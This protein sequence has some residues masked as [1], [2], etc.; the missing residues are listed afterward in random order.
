MFRK[1]QKHLQPALMSDIESLPQKHRQRLDCS[2]AGVFYR[3]VFSRLDEG[4]FA[5][6]YADVPSRPNVPVNV[7]VGLETLKA[8][9]GWSDEELYDAFA[10]DLQVRYALGYRNLGEGDFDL[11]TLYY[12]RARLSRYNQEHQVNLIQQAFAQITDQQLTAFKVRTGKQRMDSTQIASNIMDLSRL[13]LAVEGVHRLV[14]LLSESE[15]ERYAELLAP[16]VSGSA[17]H[18][19]YRVKGQEQTRR[20]L[21]EVGEVLHTLLGH[22]RQRCHA[23]AAYQAVARL[24]DENFVVAEEATQVRPN[25]ELHSGCLQ[26]LDDLEAS[27]RYKANREYKGYVANV[28]ETCD[29]DNPVQLITSVQV[30][31]NNTADAELLVEALPQLKARTDVETLITD[32]AYGSPAGDR[33]LQ[34]LQVEQ[35][36]TGFTGRAPDP[37]RLHLSDWDVIQDDQGVPSS[38]TCPGGQ[39]VCLTRT[40]R[41]SFSGRA[42]PERCAVC[43]FYTSGRCQARLGSRDAP[44][45]IRFSLEEFYLAGRRRA[46]ATHQ[47]DRKLRPAVEATMRS[48]KHP[49][50]AGQLPVRGRFRVT[51]MMVC[52]AL[53]VNAR[54]LAEYLN[55]A[56]KQESQAPQGQEI[57]VTCSICRFFAAAAT[58]LLRQLRRKSCF[59]C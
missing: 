45:R 54:R 23:E 47:A 42:E 58:W 49:F 43:P 24:F 57:A 31:P 28:A 21:G 18:Y 34:E 51:C 32:G 11:R 35:I 7:L 33:V 53:M 17:E 2:W 26:S 12:F 29:P 30:A 1:H 41:G 52:C 10:Y 15:T 39:T 36:P 20:H 50:P 14:R 13:Q 22:L 55:E 25:D 37:A 38:A 4:I 56:R 6:L 46:R 44:F 9:F 19:A 5:G 27:Y 59:A 3:E 48:V 16:Y 8:G 40:R